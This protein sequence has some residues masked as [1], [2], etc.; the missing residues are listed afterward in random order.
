MLSA[1]IQFELQ[2]PN[3]IKDFYLKAKIRVKVSSTEST[4]EIDITE[5]VLQGDSLSP[6]LF[7]LF[8]HDIVEF[9]ESFGHTDI[10]KNIEIILLSDDLVS[11]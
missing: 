2:K 9:F 7:A 6:L 4:E 3:H 1:K 8:F 11:I 10:A 5:E